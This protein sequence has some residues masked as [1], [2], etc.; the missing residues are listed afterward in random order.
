MTFRGYIIIL[1][2]FYLIPGITELLVNTTN[3]FGNLRDSSIYLDIKYK[4]N[5][6]YT[7]LFSSVIFS[8]TKL[9]MLRYF[10]YILFLFSNYSYFITIQKY[11]IQLS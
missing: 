7:T 3:S 6:V 9:Y 5:F 2:I 4:R 11:H 10:F 8:F 1:G